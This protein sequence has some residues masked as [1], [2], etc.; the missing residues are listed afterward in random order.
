MLGLKRLHDATYPRAVRTTSLTLGSLLAATALGVAL[1]PSS[2]AFADDDPIYYGG[3]WM[4]TQYW[5]AIEHPV[6]HDRHPVR[7]RDRDGAVLAVTCRAFFDDLSMEGTG[8]TWDRRLLNWQARVRGRACFVELDQDAYPYGAGVAGYALVPFRSVAVDHRYVPIGHTVEIPDLAGL[9]LPDGTRHD[10]CFVAVDG[11]GA[12]NGHHIDLFL[13][14]ADAWH[15]LGRAGYLPE[16]VRQIVV[17]SPRCAA[18]RAYA[19]LPLPGDPTL[20]R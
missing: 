7:V 19:V 20:P 17:D 8:R 14:N 1:A 15:D 13:P 11:G 6:P 18:A 16:R 2:A 12:I 10:G 9:P 4:L 3:S 5:I